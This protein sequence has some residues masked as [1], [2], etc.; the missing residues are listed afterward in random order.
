MK[1]CVSQNIE[2]GTDL[3]RVDKISVY[4]EKV[5][6]LIDASLTI[7][8]GDFIA[9]T[10][11]NGGGKTTLIKSILGL[12]KPTKG[13]IW[14]M[15]GIR[16]SYVEQVTEFDREFPI[17]VNEVLLAAHLPAKIR[18][19]YKHPKSSLEHS[20]R[21]MR[22][23]DISD[24]KDRQIGQLS[25]GQLQRVLLGRA[26]MSHPQILLLDEPTAGVDE[27]S[28]EDIYE[29]LRSLNKSLTICLITHDIINELSG[30]NRYV[31]VN[32][33]VI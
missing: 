18:P 19:F 27:E 7:R 12:V 21:V 24:L 15:P 31:R 33:T 5:K 10:G 14:I 28:R 32:K 22:D 25:G 23:L 4:Y 16:M 6:A 3:I 1:S 26:L 20:E 30:I 2:R 9:I 8:A 13:N 17:S 29:M 11:P